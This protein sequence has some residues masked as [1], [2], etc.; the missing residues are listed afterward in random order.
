VAGHV[1]LCGS[2]SEAIAQYA[3]AERAAGNYN[4]ASMAAGTVPANAWALINDWEDSGFAKVKP[5]SEVLGQELLTRLGPILDEQ[6][7]RLL[8]GETSPPQH[9]ARVPVLIVTRSGEV[10]SVEYFE[11]EFDSTGASVLRHSEGSIRFDNR[12]LLVLFGSGEEESF[13]V[14]K[15]IRRDTIRLERIRPEAESLKADYIIIED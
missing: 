13:V 9:A 12:P 15:S 3:R 5:A 8:E 1:A 2:C 11:R 10:R 4:P 14:A 7:K 6:Q